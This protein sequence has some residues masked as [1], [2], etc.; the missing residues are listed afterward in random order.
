MCAN[1]LQPVPWRQ[2]QQSAPAAASCCI[3][4]APAC[5]AT[6][7][8]MCNEMWALAS[9]PALIA[10]TLGRMWLRRLQPVCRRVQQGSSVNGCP[11]CCR[12][13]T[14]PP[15]P[16]VPRGGGGSPRGVTSLMHVSLLSGARQ[17]PDHSWLSAKLKGLFKWLA[18]YPSMSQRA[19]LIPRFLPQHP[20]IS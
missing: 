17:V 4:P 19:C 16:R 11:A 9:K 8:C 2:T 7:S 14:L 20:P 1:R 15:S 3:K 12:K 10:Q 13:C 5:S 6:A 18:R